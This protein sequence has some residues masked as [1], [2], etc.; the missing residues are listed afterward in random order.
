MPT[1]YP[2]EERHLI[3]GIVADPRF[4]DLLQL[5]VFAW[6]ELAIICVSYVIIFGGIGLYLNEMLPYAAFLIISSLATYAIFTPLHD[7]VHNAV[8]SNSK[9]NDILGT[10][11]AQPLFPGITV[12]FYR[13]LHLE[14]HRH[15]GDPKRDPDEFLVSTPMPWRLLAITSVDLHWIHWYFY[16]NKTLSKRERI[17]NGLSVVIYLA[18]TLAW[19]LSPYVWEYVLL[20]LLPQRLGLLLVG[21]LF[22]SIQ[23]PEGVLQTER[24]LQATRM[25]KGGIISRIALIAQAEHLMHHLFPMVPYYRYHDAWRLSKPS[26]ETQDLVWAHVPI[27]GQARVMPAAV[28]TTNLIRVSIE[29]IERVSEE[30][31]AYTLASK[32]GKS[33]PDYAPGAHID[34]H[35]APGLIRQYSLTGLNPDGHYHFAV[36]KE[37]QGKGGSRTLHENFQQ[38]QEISISQPRNLFALADDATNSVLISGGIGITPILAM[39]ETLN[40][41]GTNFSF[42]VCA[43]SSQTL[44]FSDYL[45]QCQYADKISTHLGDNRITAD[46]LPEWELGNEIY[47]CGPQPFMQHITEI[48]IAKGWPEVAIC[49]ENFA[50]NTHQVDNKKFT[51][52][53]A[54]SGKILEVSAQK[55]LLDVLQENQ[56]PITAS[57]VQG[58]CG[59]CACKVL[60]GEIEHRDIIF[61]DDEHAAGNMTTCVSR[62]KDGHL[63]L[64]L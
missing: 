21:Y 27:P 25:F 50:A 49:S 4:K 30:V 59:T 14:H 62:A 37:P 1:P 63:I 48:A 38:G 47:L 42:H 64:D 53:L 12:G 9:I 39:A 36:K 16:N 32:D 43:R 60:E 40:A 5:P 41:R 52:E 44:A 58:F 20:F 33:L 51:V 23:H 34:V 57:C 19:L 54:K 24:P 10:L 56:V 2:A 15:T 7:A 13:F 46:D 17:N 3:E 22:A 28:K 29:K 55:S 26:L 45:S 11:A 61:S 31:L 18:W 6:Q 8:S 35:I